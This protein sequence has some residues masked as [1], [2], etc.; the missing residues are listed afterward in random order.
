MLSPKM[1]GE[2]RCTSP[3]LQKSSE[4]KM[5]TAPPNTVR[6]E[7]TECVSNNIMRRCCC[8]SVKSRSSHAISGWRG[9]YVSPLVNST[10]G[11]RLEDK[12]HAPPIAEAELP[13][14]PLY[15]EAAAHELMFT[16]DIAI[17]NRLLMAME[18]AYAAVTSLLLSL[19]FC[20]VFNAAERVLIINMRN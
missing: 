18:P 6:I 3:A 13:D 10:K 19:S 20:A 2:L 5:A 12:R 4:C 7:S 16:L 11:L 8:V 17:D 1:L 9:V 14:T 15:I